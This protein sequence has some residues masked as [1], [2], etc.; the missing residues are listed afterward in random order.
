MLGWGKLRKIC[1]GLVNLVNQ[2]QPTLW[3]ILGRFRFSGFRQSSVLTT[4]F[5]RFCGARMSVA[6]SERCIKNMADVKTVDGDKLSKKWAY[7]FLLS[8]F[9]RSLPL[10]R[11]SHRP[12]FCPFDSYGSSSLALQNIRSER[13]NV[14]KV[15]YWGTVLAYI[16]QNSSRVCFW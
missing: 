12:R 15:P 3:R 5:S 9:H 6:L 1:V 8:H 13:E 14:V 4:Q 16:P 10:S 7:S 11:L 2:L